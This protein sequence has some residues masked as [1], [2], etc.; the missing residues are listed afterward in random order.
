MKQKYDFYND[1]IFKHDCVLG[2]CPK[3]FSGYPY[4]YTGLLHAADNAL[5]Y[6]T[7]DYELKEAWRCRELAI[8]GINN[9]SLQPHER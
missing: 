8:M 3:P 1:L 6:C 9:K 4:N 5:I 2:L 7:E